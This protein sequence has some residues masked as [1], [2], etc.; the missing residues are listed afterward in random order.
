MVLPIDVKEVFGRH[1][2][3]VK[4]R[5]NDYEWRSTPAKY[6]DEYHLAVNRAAQ[7]AAGVGAGDEVEVELELDTEER[8]VEVPDDLAAALEASGVRAAFDA[9]SFSHRREYVE[10]VEEAKR[11]ETRARR[12]AQAVERIAA[13]RSQR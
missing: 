8:T 6:G 2:P 3:P 10:W 13:G 12:I 1:R 4:V 11:A 9:M 7:A 5:I